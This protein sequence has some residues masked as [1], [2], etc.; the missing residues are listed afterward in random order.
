V[1]DRTLRRQDEANTPFGIFRNDR[2]VAAEF[3][4]T[5]LDGAYAALVRVAAEQG[6]PTYEYEILQICPVH[7]DASVVDCLECD[8]E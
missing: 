2:R 1:S 6:R 8:P 5:N 3:D 4:G 7:P